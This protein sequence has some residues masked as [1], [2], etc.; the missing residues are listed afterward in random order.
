VARAARCSAL[1]LLLVEDNPGDAALIREYLR[2]TPVPSFQLAHVKTLSEALQHLHETRVDAVLLDLMLPDAQGLDT[3]KPIREAA[4]DVPVVVLSGLSD[5]A[6]AVR[7]VAQG[8]QDYLVKGR[9]DGNLLARAILYAIERKRSE[10]YIHYLA[11]H[12]PLTNLPNRRLLLDR[13]HV[14]L[15]LA[16]RSGLMVGVVLLDLDEFKHVNDSLGHLAGDRLLQAV[17]RR[18]RSC[19]RESDTL[20]RIGGDEFAVVLPDVGCEE[21]VTAFV[22]KLHAELLAPFS[23]DG[24]EL[25][26]TAS[27]GISLY[28]KDGEDVPAILGYADIAMYRS[29]QAGRDT[30]RFYSPA[31]RGPSDERLAFG[32]GLRRAL[33][34][35]ELVLHYQ[36]QVDLATGRIR[37]AEALLRW[38][39]PRLG[40]LPPGR[41]LLLAEE[42]GLITRIG[43]WVLQQALAQARAW[44]D[45]GCANLRIAVNLSSR[46]LF[47]TGCVETVVG[48]LKESG[49]EPREV[50][51]ELTESGLMNNPENAISVLGDMRAQ[52]VRISVDDFGV[53]YS[54]LNHLRRFPVD[55]LKIDR[56]FVCDAAEDPVNGAIVRAVISM[57][58]GMGL[59]VTAE[60]VETAEELAFLREHGC[61][62]AQGAH[63]SPALPADAVGEMLLRG[64]RWS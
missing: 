45:A 16:R 29:K 5:E 3:I 43:R 10:Q 34:R 25:Y 30:W 57:A 61:D 32:S 58:H 49:L 60:G 27:S 47:E 8:A 56:T 41:F 11:N 55:S 48:M 39:H 2:Q 24:A 14:A 62:R 44:R 46:Q 40:L 36:P 19:I 12:D 4:P 37:G 59:D 26:V 38:Q 63:F 42:T 33:E 6:V 7:A 22:E 9:S 50:E 52:G 51:L 13:I 64:P 28:P 54:S 35:D 23:V 18:L 15:A 17:G 1:K 20:A 31:M 53:G 21:D